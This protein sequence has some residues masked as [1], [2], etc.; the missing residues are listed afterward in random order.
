[1]GNSEFNLPMLPADEFPSFAI[2][3]TTN[4]FTIHS[5]VLKT[6]LSKTRH[7]ISTDETRYYLNG[8]YLHPAAAEDGTPVLRAVA[9]DGHRLARAQSIL[10]AGCEEMMGIILPKKTVNEIIKLLE[11]FV[12]EVDVALSDKKLALKAGSIEFYSKLIDGKYPDYD[13]VIPKNNDK[14][15]E[16]SRDNLL[17]SIDLVI[18]ISNDRTRAVKFNIEPSKLTVQATS[19]INGNAKGVQELPVNY[20]SK[21]QISIDFNSRYVL[22]S[23]NVI[24]GETVKVALSNGSCAVVAQDANENNCIYILMPM[25]V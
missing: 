20:N 19:E 18:S 4:K 1:M 2:G 10:P 12:G 5:E 16:V 23:L 9:T 21:E 17:R 8:I 15:L 22:D 13:R 11:S 24:D 3:K 14:Y 25:Q 7:A 6:L